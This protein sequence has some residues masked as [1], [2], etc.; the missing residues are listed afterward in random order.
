[1][2]LGT[3]QTVRRGFTNRAV[4]I[5]YLANL[6]PAAACK[7]TIPAGTRVKMVPD[8]DGIHGAGW[9]VDDVP[10]LIRLTGN[11]HDPHYRYATV[12]ADVV[13]ETG[14]A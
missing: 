3:K 10:L 2:M 12:P 14:E 6:G 11:A 1:M 9:V 7:V 8:L 5:D 4:T 13:S